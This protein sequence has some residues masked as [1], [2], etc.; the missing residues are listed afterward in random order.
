[1][2]ESMPAS[3]CTERRYSE[4]HMSSSVRFSD[5]SP[6]NPDFHLRSSLS[7]QFAVRVGAGV[8]GHGLKSH[9]REREAAARRVC[10]RAS[11]DW[12]ASELE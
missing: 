4:S 5:F 8:R 3:Y 1:M 6:S 12:L 2:A 9:G 11:D 10:A 7:Y